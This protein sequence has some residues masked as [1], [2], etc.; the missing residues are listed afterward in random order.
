MFGRDVRVSRLFPLLYG[1]SGA[2][3]LLY[4]IV[5]LRLLT[6]SMGQ[7]PVA[8]GTV[9]AAFMGGLAAGAWC[10]GRLL[11]SLAPRDRKSTR[12]NSSHRL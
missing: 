1:L 11:S 3:A 12:L 4:E 7:T 6:Q 2:A 5:W 8:V 9:L 10:A